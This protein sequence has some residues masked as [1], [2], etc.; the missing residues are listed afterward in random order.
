MAVEYIEAGGEQRPF[1]AGYR[2]QAR[3]Q[4][5]REEFLGQDQ[6][7]SDL[8]ELGI[9]GTV[10]MAFI[11]FFYGAKKENLPADFTIETVEDWLDADISVVLK[12]SEAWNR[13]QPHMIAEV[14][15]KQKPL[16][17]R[18]QRRASQ[19]SLKKTKA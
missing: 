5:W 1:L 9:E 18:G 7:G 4:I 3:F 8:V 2:A 17:N 10:Q 14:D 12:V 13:A 11:G 16:E 19:K 6:S 15:P